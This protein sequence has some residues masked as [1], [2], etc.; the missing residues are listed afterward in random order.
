MP[1]LEIYPTNYTA[2]YGTQVDIDC[3]IV[4]SRPAV[5]SVFWQRSSDNHILRIDRGDSGYQGSTPKIPSL[6]I[7]IATTSDAGKYTCH[8]TNDIGT[9]ISNTGI[10]T[11]TGGQ[12]LYKIKRTT[13]I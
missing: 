7:N 5:T 10:V 2:T 11:I 12:Y 13:F 9:N 4:Y 8:A 6:T 1:V 3:Y